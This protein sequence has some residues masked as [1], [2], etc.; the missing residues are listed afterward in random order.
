MTFT[1]RKIV[2]LGEGYKVHVD[3]LNSSNPSLLAK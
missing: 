3:P 1:D 2:S